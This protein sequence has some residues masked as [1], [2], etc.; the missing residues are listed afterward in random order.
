MQVLEGELV[1]VA[2]GEERLLRPGDCAGFPAGLDRPHHLENRSTRLAVYLEVGSR[3]QDRDE[4]DYPHEDL[5]I[6][7]RADGSRN[8]VRRDGTPV[9][10]D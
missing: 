2:G 6:A 8:Y 7:Q 4:C 10:E 9:P 5:R 3:R 1:L